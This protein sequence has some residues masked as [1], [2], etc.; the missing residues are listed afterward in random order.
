LEALLSNIEQSLS[1]YATENRQTE[2]SV[3]YKKL[4]NK[5]L[6]QWHAH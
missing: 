4:K 5:E 6:G 1:G 2:S 3:F